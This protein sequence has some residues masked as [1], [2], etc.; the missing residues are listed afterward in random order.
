MRPRT[1]V[2]LKVL[3]R[4]VVV[5]GHQ[6]TLR[7]PG[8]GGPAQ[9]VGHFLLRQI[10]GEAAGS[11]EMVSGVEEELSPA[12]LVDE[13]TDEGPEDGEDSR[14]S[15][16]ED[17]AQGL[18]VVGLADLDDV[19]ER[20]HSGPPE[21]AHVEAVE[22]QQHRPGGDWLL[23]AVGRLLG[24]LETLLAD[25]EDQ[26][27]QSLLPDTPDDALGVH[28]T[29]SEQEDRPALLVVVMPA[30]REIVLYHV[31]KLQASKVRILHLL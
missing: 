8:L 31:G 6:P 1:L 5:L 11:E 18:R 4:H 29:Q 21:V 14:G 19:E 23:Q 16:D 25:V 7:D 15:D 12:R 20:L 3:G 24:Q 22:V 9:P 26:L 10:L 13:R 17:P 2:L 27:G 28:L 30:A